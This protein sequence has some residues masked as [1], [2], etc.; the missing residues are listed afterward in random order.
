M[1][2]NTPL[3]ASIEDAMIVYLRHRAIGTESDLAVNE[4]ARSIVEEDPHF[5]LC[6]ALQMVQTAIARFHI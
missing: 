1:P 5:H 6:E 4:A 2:N 3:P